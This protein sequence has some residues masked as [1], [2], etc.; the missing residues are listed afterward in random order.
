MGKAEESHIPDLILGLESKREALADS[1]D[2]TLIKMGQANPEKVVPSLVAAVEKNTDPLMVNALRVIEKIGPK[3]HE[4]LPRLAE[5]FPK[6]DPRLRPKLVEVVV[7]LDR[8]GDVALPLLANALK[9]KQARTRLEALM[10]LNRYPGRLPEMLD[11]LMDSLFDAQTRNR[12]LALSVIRMMGNKGE[13][14]VPA[15]IRILTKDSDIAIRM[16]VLNVL[17][18]FCPP[19]QTVMEAVGQ[20]LKD[21]QTPVKEGALRA[22]H[23]MGSCTVQPVLETLA[24]A[25]ASEEDPSFKKQLQNQ[26]NYLQDQEI[27]KKLQDPKG[28]AP[29]KPTASAAPASSN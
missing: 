19:P 15:L 10:C 3:A 24:K 8:K 27:K 28:A 11:P 5:F 7:R 2:H 14:A 20:T 18:G 23:R 22:L 1:V 29:K 12:R 9:D 25:L 16:D 21:P 17:G 4:S 6:C 13:P 26:I